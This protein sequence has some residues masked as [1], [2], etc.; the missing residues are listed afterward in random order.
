MDIDTGDNVCYQIRKQI[1]KFFPVHILIR[2]KTR[3]V[4]TYQFSAQSAF[5]SSN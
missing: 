2:K 3:K 5:L 4:Y 1:Q